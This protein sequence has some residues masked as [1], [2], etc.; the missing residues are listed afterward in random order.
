MED[1]L[2]LIISSNPLVLSYGLQVRIEGKRIVDVLFILK[3]KL[4][5]RIEAKYVN[6]SYYNTILTYK[7][8]LAWCIKYRDNPKE[9]FKYTLLYLNEGFY[10]KLEREVFP[11][12]QKSNLII[13]SLAPNGHR[14]QG[15]VKEI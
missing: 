11:L 8:I 15:V 14:S 13:T 10:K 1:E 7:N 4:L 12:A 5:V 2:A 6:H 3:S 9:I